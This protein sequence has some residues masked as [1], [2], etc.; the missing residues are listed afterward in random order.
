[1]P[2]GISVPDALAIFVC[3]TIW[4]V[5]H[6][7]R[8]AGSHWSLALL[9]CVALAAVITPP[10]FYSTLVTALAMMVVYFVGTRHRPVARLTSA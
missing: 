6:R 8:H 7:S 3:A 5:M 1:M 9:G 10:D 4:L 2:F